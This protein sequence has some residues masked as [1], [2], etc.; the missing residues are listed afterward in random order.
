MS[1]SPALLEIV[2]YSYASALEAQRGGAHR[3]ELCE[4]CAEGGTTPSLGTIEAVR[5]LPGLKLHV[6]IRPRG[7]D[8][9]YTEAE[10]KIMLR[11]ITAA[12]QAGA[13]GVVFGVLSPDGTVDQARLK[14]LV[15][16]SQGMSTTFHRAFD[17][18]VDP[19]AALDAVLATGCQRVLT[20]G[21]A[22][23]ALA[24]APL[25]AKLV[26]QAGTRGII[27]A[28][29]GVGPQ[30]ALE[31]MQRTGVRE[32]HASLRTVQSTTMKVRPDGISLGASPDWEIDAIPVAHRESVA[33]LVELLKK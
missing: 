33:S 1:A 5:A 21:Q 10:F 22:S 6:M 18:A 25:I 11:D 4:N 32:L 15:Q 23:Q 16:A 20:S 27:M 13:D 29:G 2:A 19:V 30:N 12:K 7:G 17:W 8:F 28:G 31:I 26:Q 24:G 9:H 14:T 3:I